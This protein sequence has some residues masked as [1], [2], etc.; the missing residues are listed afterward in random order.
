MEGIGD[1]GLEY[2]TPEKQQKEFE[3]HQKYV[4]ELKASGEYGKEYE[5]HIEIENF[6]D[7]D[8][9][10]KLSGSTSYSMDI[11]D[12]SSVDKQIKPFITPKEH[13]EAWK[14][15]DSYGK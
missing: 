1:M 7:L 12:M 2:L 13:L 4:D 6:D 11:I 8:Y 9:K 10:P 5:L 15:Y 3:K 14:D